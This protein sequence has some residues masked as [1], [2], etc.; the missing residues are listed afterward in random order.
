[1][2][3]PS[4]SY[5]PF[6]SFPE[7]NADF[8]PLVVDQYAERLRRAQETASPE[9]HQRALAI[10]TRTAAVDTGAIEGLYVTDRG[11][12]RTIA[13]QGEFWERALYQRGE[14]VRRSIEDALE[15]YEYV[16]DA[17]TR[18][19]EIS[20]KWIRDLHAI[21]T[22]HQETYEVYV[23]AGEAERSERRPL[24]H[25]EYKTLP[26]NP[27]SRSTGRDHA[28]APPG[29]ETAAEVMR[30]ADQLAT[31]EFAAAHPVVQAAY[32]HYAY[33]CIHPFADG[34][35]R[36]A[37]ALASVFLY[38]S[39]GVP[40][41]VFADQR[42]QYLD[43][44]EA[45]DMG[46]PTRF[47]QFIAD[48]VVDTIGTV[49]QSMK[50]LINSA[51]L[52]ANVTAMYRELLYHEIPEEEQLAIQRLVDA[53]VNHLRQAVVELG[54]SLDAPLRVRS[55][56]TNPRDAVIIPPGYA[57]T[58]LKDNAVEL[59]FSADGTPSGPALFYAVAFTVSPS[60]PTFLLLPSDEDAEP[61]DVWLRE[62]EPS[63]TASLELKLSTWA[64]GAVAR[65]LGPVMN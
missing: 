22:E 23:R 39:P 36:V 60:L 62:V 50:Q 44:L 6:P 40:L 19:T 21:I 55:M 65:Y 1:M 57:V 4:D 13:T 64:E 35:G 8:D 11:F 56:R 15:A 2:S 52:A 46:N 42:D 41:V 32:A 30:L 26:N 28:Y 59:F 49:V 48:R 24:P 12:T 34:N 25:G 18:R 5:V 27:T 16:L 63:L 61:L 54:S 20:A 53:C 29:D 37:R 45:A 47:V 9:V 51:N 17:T 10:A 43:V 3:N 7:W 38:R 58:T 14:Q 33:V 31:P